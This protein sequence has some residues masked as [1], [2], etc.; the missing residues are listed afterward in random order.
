MSSGLRNNVG[1]AEVT[2]S[3]YPFMQ[4][5]WS[6]PTLQSALL[7]RI[8]WYGVWYGAGS[9]STSVQLVDYKSIW[10]LVQYSILVEYGTIGS[11][12]ANTSRRIPRHS[13]WIYWQVFCSGRRDRRRQLR[14][15]GT[16]TVW[17]VS[18]MAPGGIYIDREQMRSPRGEK[19]KLLLLQ[20]SF[21]RSNGFAWMRSHLMPRLL[22]ALIATRTVGRQVC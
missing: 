18:L 1:L 15:R 17:S 22:R 21:R 13:Q 11:G 8:N 14:A 6:M 2:L 20:I 10:R 19:K 16:W 9:T 12:K 3:A 7:L 5:P 4:W